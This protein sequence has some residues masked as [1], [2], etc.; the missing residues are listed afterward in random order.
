MK[1]FFVK[2][3]SYFSISTFKNPKKSFD[4]NHIGLEHIT[5]D[6]IIVSPRI[7]NEIVNLKNSNMF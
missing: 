6:E 1:Y 7:N 3:P 4:K 5:F 2:L